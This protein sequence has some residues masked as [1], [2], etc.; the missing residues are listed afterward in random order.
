[1]AVAMLLLMLSLITILGLVEVGYV[2]AARRQSQKVADLAALSG[3]QQLPNCTTAIAAAQG[4]G[5]TDNR[6]GG[7][8]TPTCGTWDPVANSGISDHF[9]PTGSS[10]AN[11]VK[12]TTLRT[13]TPLNGLAGP[14]PNITSEAVATSQP[15]IAGFSVGTT[16]LTVSG[17]SALGQL[18]AGVGIQLNG[19]SLVGYDGLANVNV[20]PSG[21][22]NQ[23]GVQVPANITVGDLNTLLASQVQAHALIDVLNATVNAANRQDLVSTNATLVNAINAATGSAPSNVTLGS[24]NGPGGLFAQIVAPDQAAQ[25]ALNTQVSALQLISTAIGVAT[26]KHAVGVDITLPSPFV[27]GTI[28]T[29]IIEPPAVAIGGVGTTAYTAQMRTYLDLNLGTNGI[30]LINQLVNIQLDVP[31]AIDMVGAQGTLT[32]LCNVDSSGKETATIA[33]NSAILKMCVGNITQASAFSSTGS[34]DQIPGAGNNHLLLN[35]SIPSTGTQL[36]NLNT[37]F[38]TTA[39]PA[40]GSATL[41]VGQSANIGTPLDIGTSVNNLFTA[42]A[43]ALSN[44]SVAQTNLTNAAQ[45]PTPAA[46]DLWNATPISQT[47]GQR[48][49]TAL[50]QVQGASQGLQTL[51]N[52]DTGQVATML[53]STLSGNVPGLLTGV[54]SLLGSVTSALTNIVNDTTCTLGLL[55]SGPCT[56]AISSAMSNTGSGNNNAFVSLLG[57]V[58]QSLQT[59]LNQVGTLVQQPLTALGV[60]LGVTTVK[61]QSLQCHRVQLVY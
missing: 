45:A 49:Q 56:S 20:T 50:S 52:K 22:L 58:M 11:A 46:T 21:L 38:N 2:Y 59:P 17:S 55:G 16:L 41:S 13:L 60:N 12:V 44:L 48:L 43:T 8:L 9:G 42:L 47:N 30:P 1:M 32:S 14:L 18:L 51:L 39:L 34:C 40:N 54:S 26:G 24:T 6:Y 33:V 53:G 61:L 29:R 36:I 7:S 15:P 5:A 57:L 28:A 23:L 19:I 3:A 37:H 25:A 4:N 35:V 31:I 10:N 27:N